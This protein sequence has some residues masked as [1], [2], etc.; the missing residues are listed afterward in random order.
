M[1]SSVAASVEAV[2]QPQPHPDTMIEIRIK[3]LHTLAE[4]AL[5]TLGYSAA[6]ALTIS[7]VCLPPAPAA[8]LLT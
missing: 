8:I 6:E 5:S 7:D 2:Q 3:D 4:A 1:A